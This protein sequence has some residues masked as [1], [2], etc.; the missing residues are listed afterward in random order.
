MSLSLSNTGMK[1]SI[2]TRGCAY[3]LLPAS[4]AEATLSARLCTSVCCVAA[5]EGMRPVF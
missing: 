4:P 2:Q 5:G 3:A 1:H